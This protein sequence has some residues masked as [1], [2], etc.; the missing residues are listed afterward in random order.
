[1]AAASLHSTAQQQHHSKHAE[2]PIESAAALKTHH[3]ANT[4]WACHLHHPMH[5]QAKAA[6]ATHAATLSAPNPGKTSNKQTTSN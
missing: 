4:Y 5:S 3:H 1:M 6:S 2:K